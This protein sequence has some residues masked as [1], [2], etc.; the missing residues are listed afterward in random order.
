VWR[1]VF[2]EVTSTLARQREP[3]SGA[4]PD[5]RPQDT[6]EHMDPWRLAET[7]SDAGHFEVAQEVAGSISNDWQRIQAL[8]KVAAAAARAG[9]ELA[10]AIFEQ[11]LKTVGAETNTEE[12]LAALRAVAVALAHTSHLAATTVF[13]SV[14]QAS[15][16]LTDDSR[17]AEEL[18]NLA[19][20]LADAARFDD[21]R[22]V[23][24][25]IPVSSRRLGGMNT[26]YRNGFKHLPFQQFTRIFS[27]GALFRRVSDKDRQ[28]R[29][30]SNPCFAR[31]DELRIRCVRRGK[32][33]GH[34]SSTCS[35]K[36]IRLPFCV[37]VVS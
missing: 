37:G 2:A 30:A 23:A 34:Q 13:D 3:E 8:R 33:R 29:R 24:K 20:S 14:R 27:R 4:K 10:V 1:E 28:E 7:L 6:A 36:T 31:R 26:I 15:E 11:V 22:T 18:M 19:S 16:K 12:Y 25:I 5:A 32:A 35:T 9:H 17:K 21:A